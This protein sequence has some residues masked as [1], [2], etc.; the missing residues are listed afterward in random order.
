MRHFSSMK[1]ANEIK[2]QA[3]FSG[4]ITAVCHSRVRSTVYAAGGDGSFLAFTVGGKPNPSNP[5]ELAAGLGSALQKMDTQEKIRIDK[6]KR[7]AEILKEEY[8]K[9][10]EQAKAD[11]RVELLNKLTTIK[12]KLMA[13]L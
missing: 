10:Q 6:V 3:V 7:Y 2:A 1:E 12:D 8:L 9:S 5:V 11:F 13:L 4:G